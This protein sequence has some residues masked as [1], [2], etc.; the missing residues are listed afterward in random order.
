MMLRLNLRSNGL[1]LMLHGERGSDG[2]SQAP[3]GLEFKLPGVEFM[4][5]GIELKVP[6]FTFKVPGARKVPGV[7]LLGPDP[8]WSQQNPRQFLDT[9]TIAP[10]WSKSTNKPTAHQE[11]PKPLPAIIRDRCKSFD[12]KYIYN[13]SFPCR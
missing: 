3:A 8:V 11:G 4:A 13:V 5:P 10:G 6:G 9:S 12:N 7:R 1:N 2:P